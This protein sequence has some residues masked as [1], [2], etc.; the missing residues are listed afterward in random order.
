ML[1]K[2]M[3]LGLYIVCDYY[4]YDYFDMIILNIMFAILNNE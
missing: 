3:K 1:N 4:Y 2:I